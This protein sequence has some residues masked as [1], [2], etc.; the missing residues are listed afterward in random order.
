MSGKKPKCLPLKTC[1]THDMIENREDDYYESVIRY[2]EI[3]DV[4]RIGWLK[5]HSGIV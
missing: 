3:L 4:G 2:L 5:S 1:H